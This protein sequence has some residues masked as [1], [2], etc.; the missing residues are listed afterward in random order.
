MNTRKKSAPLRLWASAAFGAALL[1]TSIFTGVGAANAAG[2]AP[3]QSAPFTVSAAQ[4]AAAV[5]VSPSSGAPGTAITI[6]G[7]G[8]G[9][10]EP[11]EVMFDGTALTT[12]TADAD[13]HF[14]YQGTVPTGAALGEHTVGAASENVGAR[15]AAFTV[16]AASVPTSTETAKPSPTGDPGSD[17][18]CGGCTGTP[19]PTPTE[20]TPWDESCGCTG[21]PTPTP[22]E[23][24]PEEEWCGCTPAPS[25][26]ESEAAPAPSESE[27]APLPESGAPGRGLAVQT[28]VDARPGD[29]G[30]QAALTLWSAA[31]GL[32]GLGCAA[33]FVAFFR[34]SRRES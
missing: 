9:P 24:T 3:A 31:T 7:V 12:V 18:G 20:S 23:S 14:S 30:T 15:V 17:A 22:T 27:A 11:V 2:T 5:T 13:G 25:P 33:A 16:I 21:T 19:T 1:S 10:N 29:A 6:D 34:R 32:L 28:A 26:T 8:Y 4:V